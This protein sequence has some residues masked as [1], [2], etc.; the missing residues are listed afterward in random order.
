MVRVKIQ[1]WGSA[2]SW[3]A[4]GLKELPRGRLA[5]WAPVRLVCCKLA[6]VLRS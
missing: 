5:A 6:A 4:H 2:E 3:L 1:M